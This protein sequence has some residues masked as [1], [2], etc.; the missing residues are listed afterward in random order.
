MRT[1]ILLTTKEHF[2]ILIF[3]VQDFHEIITARLK[4]KGWSAYKLGA[5]LEPGI[6]SQTIYNIVSGRT[7]ASA[8]VLAAIFEALDLTVITK[9]HAT[10]TATKVVTKE[11]M[12]HA[13]MRG[14]VDEGKKK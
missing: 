1:K 12:R 5:S 6:S 8:S 9:E 4:E 7:A 11:H 14:I 2:G 3:A 13:K 10:K